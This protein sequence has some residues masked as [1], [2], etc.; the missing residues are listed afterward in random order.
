MQPLRPLSQNTS[1]PQV[2]S[3]ACNVKTKDSEPGAQFGAEFLPF[4][5]RK[6]PF[7]EN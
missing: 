2:G 4:D 7:S 6:L 1:H 3:T 5:P